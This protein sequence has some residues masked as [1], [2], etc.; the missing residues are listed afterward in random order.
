MLVLYSPLIGTGERP[1]KQVLWPRS[2]LRAR[3][4]RL[5]MRQEPL[6]GLGRAPGHQVVLPDRIGQ[7]GV[8][9]EQALGLGL[10]EACKFGCL[11]I[12]GATVGFL[13]LP[14]DV[15]RQLRRQAEADVDSGEQPPFHCLVVAAEY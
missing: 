12:G 5:E 14:L 13:D 15:R 2:S 3:T 8:A 11:K 1:C 10:G 4:K 6:L 7:A 9:A